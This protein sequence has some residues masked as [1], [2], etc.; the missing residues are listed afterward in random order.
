MLGAEP[1]ARERPEAHDGVQKE[2]ALHGALGEAQH[3]AQ[4]PA[5]A[6]EA[7]ARDAR[8]QSAAPKR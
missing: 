1:H 4:F 5:F 2:R 8:T 7:I 3:L 6:R